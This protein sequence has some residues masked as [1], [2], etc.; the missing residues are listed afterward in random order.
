MQPWC[1][2]P[3]VS[4]L[5]RVTLFFDALVLTVIASTPHPAATAPLARALLTPE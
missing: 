1:L 2:Q 5:A 3:I 4:G